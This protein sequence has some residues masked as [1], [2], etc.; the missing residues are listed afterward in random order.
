MELIGTLNPKPVFP[1]LKCVVTSCLPKCV[2]LVGTSLPLERTKACA[3]PELRGC[4]LPV[5]C[6]TEGGDLGMAPGL[7]KWLYCSVHRILYVLSLGRSS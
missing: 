4:L 2:F 1:F 5:V 3:D 6:R 7:D